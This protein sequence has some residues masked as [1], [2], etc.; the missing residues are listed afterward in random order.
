VADQP[1]AVRLPLE[2]VRILAIEQYGAGPW[3]TLQLCE[4]GAE[5][6][7]I[8]DPGT[9]GDI[10]RYVPPFQDGEDTLFFE[11]FNGGKKS[12]QLDLKN[13][14]G[15]EVFGRLVERA[16][17]VFSNL[18]GDQPAKLGL[19]YADL[20]SRNPRI[21]CCSLSGY[22]QDGPRAASGALD[23]VIQGLAGWMATTGEPDAPP[24]RS[25]PSLVDYS[26]GYVA[27]IALLGGLWRARRD[28]VGCDCDISLQETA[29]SLL[30]YVATWAA[31][32]GHVT[33]RR[34]NSAHPSIVPFQNF[35]TSDGWIVVACPKQELWER[36]CRVIGREELLLEQA[37]ADFASR[38]RNRDGLVA[39]LGD[40]FRGR[41]A[42][43]WIELLEGAGVPVGPVNDVPA[44]L[45]DRQVVA[46]GAIESYAHETLG[47]VRR[48]RSP[49]RLSGLRREPARA[50]RRGEHARAILEDVCGLDHAEIDRLEAAGAF[51]PAAAVAGPSRASSGG[52]HP[53]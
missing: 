10:G 40:T 27:A 4:L 31:T 13:A 18:R 35:A 25:G 29:L 53:Q 37:Y 28:G 46:R 24:T 47:D 6:I 17:A 42:A 3:A 15:R 21:V 44:A 52:I 20:S 23:Y 45:A 9:G 1:P 19:R 36:L 26:G 38:D 50:P 51:G 33:P 34:P 39:T 49:L 14:A 41:S 16:D 5:V 11:T 8:E 22:G 7:K 2:D 48:V 30:T 32:H 12:I 43:A